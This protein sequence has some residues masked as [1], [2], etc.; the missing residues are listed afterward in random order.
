M[1]TAH[2]TTYRPQPFIEENLRMDY[3]H[4]EARVCFCTAS[5]GIGEAL[6]ARCLG[7]L[8]PDQRA[9]LVATRPGDGLTAF[10]SMAAREI[11]R[12]RHRW[13]G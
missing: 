8:P 4:L 3:A 9:K 13:F 1:A 12:K 11:L 6:C 10:A 2:S 5:K 7:S